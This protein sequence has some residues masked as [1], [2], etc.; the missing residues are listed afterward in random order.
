MFS[1]GVLDLWWNEERSVVQQGRVS[2]STVSVC[3]SVCPSVRLSACLSDANAVAAAGAEVCAASS[4]A[5]NGGPCG[6]TSGLKVRLC[7]RCVVTVWSS[8]RFICRW[9][10]VA[11]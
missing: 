6:A 10:F 8:S 5:V 4:C 2:Q 11:C 7:S 1:L 3:L 9:K